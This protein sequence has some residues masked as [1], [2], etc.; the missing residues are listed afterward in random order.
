MYD[1][2]EDAEDY[3]EEEDTHLSAAQLLG[4]TGKALQIGWGNRDDLGIIL[5]ISELKHIF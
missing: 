3:Y 1:E 5:H 4:H 2:E